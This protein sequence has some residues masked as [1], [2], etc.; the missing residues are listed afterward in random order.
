MR[1][2][3]SAKERSV[4]DNQ[5]EICEQHERTS[6]SGNIVG[7]VCKTAGKANEV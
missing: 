6:A 2:N 1:K 7:G 4:T 5:L 3:G